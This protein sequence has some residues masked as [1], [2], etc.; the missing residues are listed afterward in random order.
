MEQVGVRE[1]RQNASRY[2]TRVK[3]GETIEVTEH[4]RPV[5][6]LAP[7]PTDSW[8][9][10]V[11][12]GEVME[13]TEDRRTMPRPLKGLTGASEHLDRLRADER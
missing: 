8:E 5:A 10:M 6:V 12:S 7:V 1:L 9:A 2:L 11:A 3:A 4:G 13:A